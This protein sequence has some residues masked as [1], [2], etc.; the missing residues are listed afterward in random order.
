MRTRAAVLLAVVGFVSAC[1]SGSVGTGSAGS[2]AGSGSVTSGSAAGSGSASGSGS[3]SSSTDGAAAPAS[4]GAREV[5]YRAASDVRSHAAIGADIAALRKHLDAAK[6]AKPVDWKAVGDVWQRGGASKKSDGTTRTLA[7]LVDDATATRFV[8]DAIAGAGEAKGAPDAVRAQLVDKGIV[9]LLAAK[10]RAELAAARAKILERDT[11]PATGAPVNVDGAWAF[12]VA[13]GSGLAATAEKRAAD[14]GREG[15]VSED[16]LAGLV[17]AQAA[18]RGG[19]VAAF[20]RAAASVSDG[21]SLIFY[22]ATYKYLETKDDP[23]RRAEG[24]TFYRGIADIVRKFD[25]GADEAIRAAFASGDTAA[26]R[27]ALHRPGVLTALDIDDTER[28]AD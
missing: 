23:V 5:G 19:D 26:G 11:A 25:A 9:V 27:A 22:L 3:G 7:T 14:F 4:A 15:Q 24:A 18:A 8:A 13:D 17:A 12:Y 21:L 2:G 6:A 1:G 20:D 16:V 28:V 10:V